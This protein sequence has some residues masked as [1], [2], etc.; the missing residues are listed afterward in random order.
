[1]HLVQGGEGMAVGTQ[2]GRTVVVHHAEDAF[3]S[4]L[5]GVVDQ[6]C[7]TDESLVEVQSTIVVQVKSMEQGLGSGMLQAQAIQ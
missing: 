7:E 5:S 1:M 6:S 3:E 4:L 2:G